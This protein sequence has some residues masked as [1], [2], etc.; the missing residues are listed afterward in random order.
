M[1]FLRKTVLLGLMVT[2]PYSVG[3][4]ADN[5]ESLKEE[6]KVLK[7]KLE[8]LEE[9][10][11]KHE[12]QQASYEDKIGEIKKVGDLIKGID[13]SFG[14]TF[15]I[16]GSDVENKTTSENATDG[17]YSLDLGFEKKF[18]DYGMAFVHLEAGGGSGLDNDEIN[19]FSGVNRDAGDSENRVEVTEAFYEH[20]LMDKKIALTFGKLDPTVYVDQNNFANDE[21]TQFLSF[22]FRNNDAIEFP[23]NGGGFR[24]MVSPLEWLEIEGQMVNADSSLEDFFDNSF[25]SGQI[26]LKPNLF[27]RGTNLRFF[28]WLNDTDHTKLLDTSKTKEENYGTGLSFDQELSDS[29]GIFARYSYQNPGVSEFD[30]AY[31][32]GFQLNGDFWNRKD[33]YLGLAF[34]QIFVSD[35]FKK[36]GNQDNEETHVE[37]YYNLFLNKHVRITPDIQVITSPRGVSGDTIGVYGLRVQMDF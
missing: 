5:V 26:N 4:C 18:D 11:E 23:D 7:E 29:L 32:I 20:Y 36:L 28:G 9:K 22:S 34:G 15:V 17:T 8:V 1:V 33:D 14:S 12:K 24:V 25:W 3:F 27:K 10:L 37:F 6:I 2:L 19:L 13:L 16:Q 31:S 21:T 30:H 35:D